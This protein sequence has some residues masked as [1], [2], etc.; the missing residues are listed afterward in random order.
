MFVFCKLDHQAPRHVVWYFA[1][2]L[3]S[4]TYEGRGSPKILLWI[5]RCPWT[6][7]WEPLV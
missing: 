3:S 5:P 7:G 6:P 4:Y 2:V 1:I